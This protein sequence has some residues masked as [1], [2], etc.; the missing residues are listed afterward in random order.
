MNE[1]K[2][3][4]LLPVLDSDATAVPRY[5][6]IGPDG[7]TLYKNVSLKLMNG[8]AQEGTPINKPLLD[9]FLAAAGIT[10]GTGT[11]YTLVQK[12]YS[13]FDGAEVRFRL[14]K[15]SES[16]ATLNVNGT[17]AK[18]LRDAMG[19]SMASGMPAGTWLKAIYSTATGAYTI[20]GG[21]GGGS[22]ENLIDNWYLADPVNL[23]GLTQ[24][25]AAGYGIDR[26]RLQVGSMKIE[27]NYISLIPR[28]S[29]AVATIRQY[30]NNVD[31]KGLNATL[32]VLTNNG[33]RYINFVLGSDKY[34]TFDDCVL[35]HTLY[36]NQ[37]V[38]EIRSLKGQ[39]L[40]VIAVK[41]E[42]G[43]QQTLA[44]KDANGAWIL[45]DPPPDKG[46]ELLKCIQSTA[47]TSDTY[48]NKVIIHTGNK[49]LIA[50]A[51]IGAV[52]K[53]GDTMTGVLALVAGSTIGG[54]AIIHAGN[55]GNYLPADTGSAKVLA[56]V[57]LTSNTASVS[58]TLPTDYNYFRI[59]ISDITVTTSATV[60]V[61]CNAATR[62]HEGIWL[63]DIM[64]NN[65]PGIAGIA[66]ERYNRLIDVA[67][68]DVE[69]MASITMDAHRTPSGMQGQAI[70][71]A[72]DGDGAGTGE[73][74][75]GT[76]YADQNNLTEITVSVSSGYMR[77]GT[78]IMVVGVK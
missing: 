63:F 50:P 73:I 71:V 36:N 61:D 12:G 27:D 44:H 25:T 65:E 77:A 43:S 51:D 57:R 26:W 1:H 66:T 23:R 46:M 20:S 76:W 48:A 70:A 29:G 10:A 45:N 60:K 21:A 2:D 6:I 41:L 75:I 59:V 64:E 33:L 24:Y 53:A 40:N 14:H 49:N 19:E 55:I 17:G 7:K 30:A 15:A 47:D 16:G 37:F 28:D 62:R 8:I 11:A 69:S 31:I 67:V 38:Y 42:L 39:T 18:P 78:G 35:Y 13:L 5:N 4:I 32:S 56:D 58:I 9:E 74:N 34:A 68:P 52:N 3:E 72:S 22:N 54:N